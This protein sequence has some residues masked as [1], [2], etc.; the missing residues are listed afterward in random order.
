VERERLRLAPDLE[1]GVA[2][3]HL[4]GRAEPRCSTLVVV[5]AAAAGAAGSAVDEL[6]L[7]RSYDGIPV[8]AGTTWWAENDG[9]P[10]FGGAAQGQRRPTL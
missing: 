1:L 9:Q 7:C 6:A 3:H 4:P 8:N 2:Q 5:G 10:R